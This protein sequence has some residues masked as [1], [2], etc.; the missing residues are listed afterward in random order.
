MAE[1]NKDADENDEDT[2]QDLLDDEIGQDDDDE[3]P[4]APDTIPILNDFEGLE[5]VRL[6][7]SRKF[8]SVM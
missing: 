1:D 5:L 2:S 6:D 8:G 3:L 4:S 7:L